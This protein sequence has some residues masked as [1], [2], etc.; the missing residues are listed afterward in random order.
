MSLKKMVLRYAPAGLRRTL[1]DVYFAGKLVPGHL[2]DYGRFLSHAGLNKSRNAQ[3]ERAARITLY[4]HQLEKGMSLAEPRL[5]FGKP[6][7]ASLFGELD[8]FLAAY[9]VADPATTA[10]AALYSYLDFHEQRGE[11][12]EHVRAP[13]AALLDKHGVSAQLARTWQ[14]GVLALSRAGIEQARNGGFKRFFESRYSIR[15]F[16]GGAVPL[17]DLRRAVELAQKTPSVCNRQSWQVHAFVQKDKMARLL[18]IQSGSRGFGD[19]A[20][21]V[22]VITSDLRSF[23]GVGERYQAWIDGGMFAMSMCLALHDL[24]YGS[25]CLNWSKEPDTDKAM[26][27]AAGVQPHEQIIMLLAVG[28]LPDEFSVARSYRPPVEQVLVV[29]E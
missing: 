5:N 15:Q 29:H 19:Q 24:G 10:V 12:A 8:A 4:Y 27:A 2:Y 17:E 18:E 3:A 11:R 28:T 26:R 20:S 21:A 25:C 23:L 22:L 6:I 9:G 16:A 1:R 14:G 7:I 13:L